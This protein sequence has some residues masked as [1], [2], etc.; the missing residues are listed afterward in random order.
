MM[1]VT[2]K[3]RDHAAVLAALIFAALA[4]AFDAG[5]LRADPP[6]AC[7]QTPQVLTVDAAIRYAL[8][9]NPELRSIRQQHGIAAANIVIARTYPFN[10]I[11][12]TEVRGVDG[13]ISAGITN[14]VSNIDKVTM[15]VEVRGQRFIRREAAAAGLTRTDWEIAT[16]ELA[17]CVRVVRAYE[18]VV[19]WHKKTQLIEQTLDLNVKAMDKVQ[20]MLKNSRGSFKTADFVILSTEVGDNRTQLYAA[21]QFRVQ[22]WNE[23]R[24]TLGAVQ[25]N[26]SLSGDLLAPPVPDPYATLEQE[27]FERR[28]DL[29]ARHAAV[30]EA[31]ARLR[32]EK[33]NRY[34]NPIIG[35]SY[36]YDD[37]RAN[38]LGGTL[39]LPLP[40]FNTHRGEIQ[41]REAEHARALLD[42]RQTEVQ[43]RQ[44]V[45]NAL[46]RLEQARAGLDVY[47]TQVQPVM[48]QAMKEMTNLFERGEPGVDALRLLDI[49]RKQ[50][51]ATE[52][53]LDALWELRQ[54][55][56]DLAAAVADP[57]VGTISS[58]GPK[59]LP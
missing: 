19:Y 16:Q 58:P 48:A 24:R 27:A 53:E 10:P 56:A 6:P 7:P 30:S 28:P 38:Y 21:L 34:G 5:S 42:V 9:N 11:W 44:D 37:T 57:A 51:K 32:L 46:K 2:R 49:Q 4:L 14:R 22:A 50:L 35:P 40:A 25:E 31:D 12:E 52:G 18:T 47:R 36:E 33:A 17:L 29:H 15:D 41:Q 1:A 39:L 43:I 55:Q 13:P 26:F 3:I 20:E 54:A 23:L 8:E 45:W 59:T